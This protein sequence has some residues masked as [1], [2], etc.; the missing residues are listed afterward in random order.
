MDKLATSATQIT[1]A[2]VVSFCAGAAHAQERREP[3]VRERQER[4]ALTRELTDSLRVVLRRAQMDSAFPGAYAIVGDSRGVLA[5]HAV[6]RIDWTPSAPRPTRSTIWDLASITKIVATTTAL[7]QLVER[8]AVDLDAPVSRYLPEWVG[9]GRDAVRVRHLLTHTSGLPAF[10]NYDK[11]TQRPDSLATL[12][13][14]T[15]LERPPGERM[16]YSDIGAYVM[17]SVIERVT[18]DSLHVYVRKQIATPLGLRETM[19]RPSPSLRARIAPTEIDSLRGGLVRG[20]VHDERAYYLG[21][22]AA[23]AGLFGSARD[24]ARFTRMMLLGGVIDGVR[25]LRPETIGLFTAYADSTFSNRALGWQKPTHPAM[26]DTTP[27]AAWAGRFMSTRAF[28]HTGFTGTS[29]AIDPELDLYVILLSNRVNP[30][31]ANN[32]ITAVRRQLADAVVS[33]VRS[34]RG[35]TINAE[36]P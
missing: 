4:A 30:T 2:L 9:D 23:H 13:F 28:G 33:A 5:E 26:R 7:A 17:G 16:V 22:V 12:I 21:G 15:P 35:P 36:Q 3:D 6:G 14:W 11:Q 18:G 34:R 31:R 19:F 27:G 20:F 32:R 24:L 1:C 8:G 10:R 29:L 25:L